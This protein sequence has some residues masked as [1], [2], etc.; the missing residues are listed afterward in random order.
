MEYRCDYDK[1]E[2]MTAEILQLFAD[3]QCTYA[4]AKKALMA[5]MDKGACYT[6]F[7]SRSPEQ[8]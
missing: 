4:E 6:V 3:H 2:R 8:T 5:A 7:T 1:V